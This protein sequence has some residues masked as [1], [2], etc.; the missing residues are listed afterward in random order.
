MATVNVWETEGEVRCKAS[1]RG[2]KYKGSSKVEF[3]FFRMPQN[4][5]AGKVEATMSGFGPLLKKAEATWPA[6]TLPETD[7]VQKYR[8]RLVIDGNPAADLPD[9]VFVWAREI[10]VT[11]KLAD[12]N[13]AAGALIRCAVDGPSADEGRRGPARAGD[14]AAAHERPGGVEVPPAVPLGAQDGG[15]QALVPRHGWAGPRRARASARWW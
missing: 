4:E 14:A 1:L 12:G 5:S 10:E 13:V 9:D 2:K 8:Y 6:P 7:A 11:A 3:E 15:H